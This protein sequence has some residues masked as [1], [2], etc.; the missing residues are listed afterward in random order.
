MANP[1]PP[2][3]LLLV[4]DHAVVRVGLRTLFERAGS[5]EV[6]GEA[7]SV[8]EA[9]EQAARL[10]PDIV[11]MDIRLPDGNGVEACRGIRSSRPETRVVMLTSYSDEDAVVASIVAGAE[12]YLLKETPPKQL[13]EAIRT[14]ARGGSLLDPSVTGMVLQR[15]KRSVERGDDDPLSVAGLSNQEREILSLVTDGKT[16]REIASALALSERTIKTYVSTLLRKLNLTRR[17][18]AAAFSARQ[19]QPAAGPQPVLDLAQPPSRRRRPVG[20]A[21]APGWTGN[22]ARM[23][24]ARG[25]HRR[26]W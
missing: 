17:A 14:V 1:E 3:R 18:E 26:L 11:I 19:Q 6:A 7:A 25:A 4:D 5:F 21:W 12:G 16:N 23:A 10:Q 9:Q 22:A 20:R 15:L 13:I 24:D 8:A 2:I